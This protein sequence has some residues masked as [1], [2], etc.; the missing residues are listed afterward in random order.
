MSSVPAYL[1]PRRQTRLLRTRMLGSAGGPQTAD[2]SVA[3]RAWAVVS[4]RAL[5]AAVLLSLALGAVLFQGV[6]GERSVAVPRPDSFSH[7]GLLSLPLAAQGPVSPAMGANG[8]AY[9]IRP[10]TGAFA[11]A[12]PAQRLSLHFGRS[13]VSVSSGETRVG[14]SLSLWA[15]GHRLQRLARS[16]HACR[17]TG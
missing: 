4:W 2:G 7:Q 14:L 9:R 15:T 17:P 6:A 16:H 8:P 13:G 12:N 5:A 1:A 3:L 11:A 10:S